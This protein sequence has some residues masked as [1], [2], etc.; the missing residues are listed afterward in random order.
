MKASDIRRRFLDYF[1]LRGHELRPSGSLVP[2]NDPTLLFTNAGMVQFKGVFLGQEDVP[3]NRA[4]T[5]QKCVRAG[6]KHNDL[7]EVG[8]TARHHTFFEMLGNFSF[9]DYFKRD[10]IHFAWEFLTVEMGLDPNRLF[11][12][13][14]YTDDEAHALWQEVAGVDPTRIFR[15][16]DKDNFWQMADTGPCGP[17]SELHYD[18]R[19][20][21]E[22]SLPSK[23]EFEVLGESGRVVELWNLVFMQFDRDEEGTLNPLP[24]P[25]IDTGLGLERLAA[26]LQGEDSNYHTDLFTPL[27]ERASQAVGRPYQADSPDGVSF[28]VLADHSRAV[29]FLLAD[30][31]FPS[32]EGRGYVLR[33]IL[34]RG[35]RHAWLLGRREPTLVTVVEEVLR[36]MG[37]AFPDLRERAP[38]ILDTTRTEEERFLQTIEGGM[39]RFDELAPV[40]E[41]GALAGDGVVPGEEVFK[42]YDTF[43]FPLDLTEL[44]ARERGYAVDVEGFNRALDEQRARSRADRAAA[45]AERGGGESLTDWTLLEESPDQQWVGWDTTGTEAKVVG[46]RRDD[47]RLGLILDLNPFYSEAGGQVSDTGEVIGDGWSLQ[48]DEVLT[49]T[50]LTAIS[51]ELKGDFHPPS[52]ADDARVHARVEDR[53][54]H[55]TERNHTVTHLL[56]AALRETLGEHVAQRGSLVAPDRLRFDFSHP[57]P[58][59]PDELETIE[60]QVNQAIWDDHPVQWEIVARDEA[61]GR[62]AM[63]L[64]GEKYGDEVRIVEI[65]DVS[66]ELCGG[67]HLRHTGEAGLF[68]ILGESGV[69]SGVRRIEAVTGPAAFAHLRRKEEQL[70]DVATLLRTTPSNLRKRAVELLEERAQLEELLEEIRQGGAAGGEDVVHEVHIPGPSALGLTPDEVVTYRAVRMKVKDADDARRFGDAVRD[71]AIRTVAVVAAEQVDGKRTLFV[72]VTDDLIGRGIRAG[73]L[74]RDLAAKVGGRGGGRPHMAQGGIEQPENLE[75]ALASGEQLLVRALEASVG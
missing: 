54:R 42:L 64:F 20:D 69:A 13:I 59:T 24:A 49:V 72:F 47:R 17:C 22:R 75:A 32:N 44:M 18:L 6:G 1:Q 3:F 70:A 12:T 41:G 51:G 35:V 52:A 61:L 26:V 38:T 2:G 34:R 4:V 37:G 25:S 55:D 66:L 74:V 58:V 73:D 16:G 9:G 33:R 60:R 36:V 39:A 23:E 31:V 19:A 48:V 29:A 43:G 71:E 10:A 56:H 14:H 7:E 45:G 57:R 63:A 50:G 11:V 30:G 15:L 65:P 8:R 46:F 27:L 62:G 68:V 40:P 67:T 5:S 21:G 28:R 53:R